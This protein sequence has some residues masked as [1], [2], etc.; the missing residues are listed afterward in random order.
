MRYQK[1]EQLKQQDKVERPEMVGDDKDQPQVADKEKDA[2]RTLQLI[3][4]T[5]L[6]CYIKVRG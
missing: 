4:T 5:L 6:K 1:V 3:D 2:I